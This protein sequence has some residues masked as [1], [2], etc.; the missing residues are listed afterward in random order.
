MI[1]KK[2]V[3]KNTFKEPDLKRVYRVELIHIDKVPKVLKV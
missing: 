2:G 3:P 1:L